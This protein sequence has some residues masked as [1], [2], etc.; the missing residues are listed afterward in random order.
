MDAECIHAWD[1][2]IRSVMMSL[3]WVVCAIVMGNQLV[4]R[5]I[6]ISTSPW[7]LTL[8]HKHSA[9]EPATVDH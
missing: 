3:L 7:T 5:S 2:L 1:E 8:A 6:C 4:R 9:D